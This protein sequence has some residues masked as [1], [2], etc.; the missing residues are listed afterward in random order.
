MQPD[1]EDAAGNA[2]PAGAPVT[3][4][5]AGTQ[6]GAD[7]LLEPTTGLQRPPKRRTAR[8]GRWEQLSFRQPIPGDGQHGL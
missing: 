8:A 7:G 4:S 6:L 1:A 2:R 3:F 5:A